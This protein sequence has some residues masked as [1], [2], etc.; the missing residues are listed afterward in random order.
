MLFGNGLL[1]DIGCS[2]V[3][4]ND[5]GGDCILLNYVKKILFS[6]CDWLWVI[7]CY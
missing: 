3:Y 6:C 2:D 5:D 7:G 4:V 1:L